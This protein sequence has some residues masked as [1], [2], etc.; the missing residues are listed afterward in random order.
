MNVNRRS[1]FF[2]L[3][4]A[5]ATGE[6]DIS[7]TSPVKLPE[8]SGAAAADPKRT[9]SAA[10]NSPFKTCRVN[11]AWLPPA[12][13]NEKARAGEAR[14]FVSPLTARRLGVPLLRFQLEH[15]RPVI[16][17]HPE[18]H[19]RRRIIHE[20][21][22][23]VRLARQQILGH[24]ARFGIEPRDAVGP[25]RSRPDVA[26][27]VRHNVIRRAPRRRELPLLDLLRLGVEHA[28]AVRSV[29]G[30]PQT[31]LLVETAAPRARARRHEI[32]RAHV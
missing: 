18:R 6:L 5:P 7:L 19:R 13:R 15:G 24:L 23:Y 20:D 32:G 3:T 30:E 4:N 10:M 21:A 11:M 14:A 25:H 1:S 17:P 2:I 12:C 22:P 31:A 27:F 16:A 26:V 28:D 9:T 8:R 29:F